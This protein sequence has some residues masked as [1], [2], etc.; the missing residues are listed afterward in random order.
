MCLLTTHV[1]MCRHFAEAWF[2]C[3]KNKLPKLFSGVRPHFC[4]RPSYALVRTWVATLCPGPGVDPVVTKTRSLPRATFL[5]IDRYGVL[6]TGHWV[7]VSAWGPPPTPEVHSMARALELRQRRVSAPESCFS[8]MSR[9]VLRA[10]P[11]CC[12]A[13]P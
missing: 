7:S 2:L 9:P 5:F 10:R 11:S 4:A 3:K 8:L 13:C 12:G 1:P 6:F